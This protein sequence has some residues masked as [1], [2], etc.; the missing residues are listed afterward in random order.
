MKVIL[1]SDQRYLLTIDFEKNRQRS[2]L[3]RPTVELDLLRVGYL[4]ASD[5]QPFPRFM[6]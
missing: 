5:E 2:C 6:T 3:V 1:G 4:V